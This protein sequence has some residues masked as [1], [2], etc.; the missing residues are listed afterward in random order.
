[1]IKGG[2]THSLFTFTFTIDYISNI[3]TRTA[4]ATLTLQKSR[5]KKPCWPKLPIKKGGKEIT[6]SAQIHR[7]CGFHDV[8]ELSENHPSDTVPV[9]TQPS[10]FRNY[11]YVDSWRSS[12]FGWGLF[13]APV[14][15]HWHFVS[16]MIVLSVRR[17]IEYYKRPYKAKF[18]IR[19]QIL[20]K[21]AV[22]MIYK[23]IFVA[24]SHCTRPGPG[25][26]RERNWHN[27]PFFLSRTS[28]K[29]FT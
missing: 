6:I 19:C 24:Y 2:G 3:I 23:A 26:Y 17:K 5:V 10:S 21:E 1:M 7:Q 28:V 14:L 13:R 20:G 11:I 16:W 15:P 4:P 18:N 8:F 12:I 9:L 22:N 27:W 25:W 29:I